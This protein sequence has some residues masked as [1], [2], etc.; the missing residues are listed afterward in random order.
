MDDVVGLPAVGGAPQ[1][2]AQRGESGRPQ[3]LEPERVLRGGVQADQ[4]AG[5]RAERHVV[6]SAWP[7]DHEQDADLPVGA[8]REARTLG[9]LAIAAD[10]GARPQRDRGVCP[11]ISQQLPRDGCRVRDVSND[12]D[13]GLTNPI[14]HQ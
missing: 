14:P 6:P 8:T 11:R 12:L 2:P 9:G 3:H 10:E 5:D 7:A 13:A 4:L 1:F